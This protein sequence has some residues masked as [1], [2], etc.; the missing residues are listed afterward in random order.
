MSK[1]IYTVYYD[2]MLP[3]QIIP[4]VNEDEQIYEIAT[5]SKAKTIALQKL[6]EIYQQN[7]ERI[8]NFTEKS[9]AF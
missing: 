4:Y 3:V 9:H 5:L 8:L 2:Q 7:R 6:E 1:R